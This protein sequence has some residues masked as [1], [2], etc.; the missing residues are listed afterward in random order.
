ML[1]QAPHP[2]VARTPLSLKILKHPAR[3]PRLLP[4]GTVDRRRDGLACKV[5]LKRSRGADK[6]LQ[7]L[8]T[9][10]QA[11]GK[12]NNGGLRQRNRRGSFLRLANRPHHLTDRAS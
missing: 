8:Q 11:A 12:R 3:K 7:S 10:H 6:L 9:Q 4:C 1:N 2:D 5:F